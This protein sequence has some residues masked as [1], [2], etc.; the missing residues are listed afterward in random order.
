ME[1]LI[2][3]MALCVVCAVLSL[4]V[5][6]RSP[7]FSF[8]TVCGCCAVCLLAAAEFLTPVVSFLEELQT[9]AGVR[10]ALMAP[11]LKTVGIGLLT[12]IAGAFCKDAGEEALCKAV[13]LC[14]T[15][16]AVYVSLPLAS[17][18]LEL[19]KELMGG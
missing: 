2:Q 6:R 15:L 18:V 19:L 11:I 17:A 14:G 9:L 3:I 5:R 4:V 13:E 12:Q 1:K 16:M 10:P 8:C 7:E